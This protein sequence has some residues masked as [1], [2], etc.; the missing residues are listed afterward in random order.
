MKQTLKRGM[1]VA[2]LIS[3]ASFV[4]ACGGGKEEEES[5]PPSLG[6]MASAIESPTGT[7]DG[8]TAAD[9]AR[10]FEGSRSV[11]TGGE[12]EQANPFVAQS[13]TVACESGSF[14]SNADSSGEAGEVDYNAC[15]NAGCCTDGTAVFA[16]DT[17]GT[18]AYTFCYDY[19]VTSSC[20][21]VSVSLDF[22]YCSGAMGLIYAIEVEGE[23]FAVSGSGTSN[24]T[25]TLTI[26]G[27]NG[28]FTC[29][30]TDYT[31]SCTDSAG[32]EFSF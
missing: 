25:G 10:A 13:A 20:E 24:G 31:G 23:S 21:G 11:P 15:C 4:V 27:E 29:N 3:T 14:T 32:G 19:D 9:V 26:T 17:S 18:G 12:R 30:Y 8:T 5:G 22:T 1:L 28:T 2:A 7:L 16:F 6:E